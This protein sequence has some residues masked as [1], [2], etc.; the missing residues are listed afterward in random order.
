MTADHSQRMTH[1]A[2]YQVQLPAQLDDA[3]TAQ[4]GPELRRIA[5]DAAH[6]GIVL[7]AA[8]MT[9]ICP[10]GLGLLAAVGLLAR[11]HG[12][13]VDVTN[14]P[15]GLVGLLRIARLEVSTASADRSSDVSSDWTPWWT[16]A[17]ANA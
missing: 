10:A 16:G 12:A 1:D 11:R 3:T 15:A 8:A 17:S 7:D 5:S 14:C 4:I 6:D 2:R 9:V 13:R